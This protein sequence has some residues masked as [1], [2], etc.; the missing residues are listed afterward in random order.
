[1]KTLSVLCVIVV[2]AFFT[3]GVSAKY[4]TNKP[5]VAQ[6]QQQM[7]ASPTGYQVQNRVTTQNQGLD[8]QLKIATQEY[9]GTVAAQVQQLLEVRTTGGIGEQ[10][11]QIAQEQEKTQNQLQEQLTKL[12][13]RKGLLRSLI[14]PD[15]QALKTMQQQMEQ[16]QLRIAELE[17][18]KNQLAN[19]G[20]ITMVQET[21]EALMQQYTTLQERVSL[22]EQ[23]G[24]MF[25]WLFK[26]F[27]K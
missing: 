18:L 7:Y 2:L 8:T 5:E 24:S 10:V 27:A 26:L 22:E 16:N 6:G 21:I 14:G 4:E 15:Y 17:Q 19:W 25:G 20:D 23:T 9:M 3:S 11:R 12:D 1:M 13:N